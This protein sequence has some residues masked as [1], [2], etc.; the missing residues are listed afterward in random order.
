L[1]GEKGIPR[2]TAAGGREFARQME[3][4]QIEES[5]E[6][7]ERIR[8]GW[9]LGDDEFRQDLETAKGRV[10]PSH[11]SADRRE[12]EEVKAEKIVTEGLKEI[13]WNENELREHAKGERS[14]VK[15]ARRLRAE[16][17][18]SLKWIAQRLEMGSW[19]YVSNLLS[20][21]KSN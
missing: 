15:L 18:M 1:L 6:D 4:R 9:C 16:S 11:Y 10:G 20:E 8:R 3:R 5:D 19:T 21:N 14:K 2:D 7:Y 13:G 12:T 17:T